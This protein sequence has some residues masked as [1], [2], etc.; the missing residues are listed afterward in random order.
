MWMFVGWNYWTLIPLYIIA[1]LFWP[2][3]EIAQ[4]NIMFRLTPKAARAS[5][6]AFNTILT[7]VLAFLG[8][9]AGGFIIDAI[10]GFSFNL[11]FLKIGAFQLLFFLGAVLRNMPLF[12]LAKVEEPKE[13]PLEQVMG[14]VRSSIGVGFMEG[15]GTL[16][17]YVMVPVQKAGHFI[18]HFMENG[19]NEPQDVEN[20]PP[21]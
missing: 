4:F 18:G 6:L 17:N 21:K 16:R 11:W 19:E 20:P 5:Y 14:V 15:V 12:F 13:A 2:G 9:I 10:G 3:M 8:P 7:S 1:G